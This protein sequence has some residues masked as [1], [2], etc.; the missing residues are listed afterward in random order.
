MST[1][2]III[3]SFSILNANETNTLLYISFIF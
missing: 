2:K 1:K 3:E